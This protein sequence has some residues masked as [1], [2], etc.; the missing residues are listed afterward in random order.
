[1]IRVR[2]KKDSMH[3]IQS[4]RVSGHANYA[5]RGQDIVCAAV[6]TLLQTVGYSL[7]GREETMT[8]VDFEY[9]GVGSIEIG[10]PTR[11]SHLITGAFELG[12]TKLAEQYPEHVSVEME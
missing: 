8:Q 10:N 12:A 2:I 11:E 5:P 9:Y 1:M 3:N 7:I 6:S 4:I